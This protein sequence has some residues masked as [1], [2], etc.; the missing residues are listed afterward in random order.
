[1]WRY[2]ILGA[3]IVFPIWLIARLVRSRNEGPR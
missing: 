2:F 1:V 3:I